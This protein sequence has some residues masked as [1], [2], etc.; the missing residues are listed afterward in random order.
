MHN[1]TNVIRYNSLKPH[2]PIA[3]LSGQKKI[4][5]KKQIFKKFS[6]YKKC[7]HGNLVSTITKNL[8]DLWSN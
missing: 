5:K 3:P 2:I 8:I 7:H 1:K 6:N 4:E